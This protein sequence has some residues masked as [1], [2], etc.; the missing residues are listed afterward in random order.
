MNEQPSVE[1]QPSVNIW[2]RWVIALVT[3]ALAVPAILVLAFWGYIVRTGCFIKCTDVPNPAMATL[4]FGL[5]GAVLGVLVTV[6]VWTIQG[7]PIRARGVLLRNWVIG[8]GVAVAVV[9]SAA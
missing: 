5:G 6:W 4:I 7:G 9:S 2:V 3:T 1:R 8:C